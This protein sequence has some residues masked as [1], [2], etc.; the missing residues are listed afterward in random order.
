MATHYMLFKEGRDDV[1]DTQWFVNHFVD[2]VD[3]EKDLKWIE[4]RRIEFQDDRSLGVFSEDGE[5][6]YFISKQRKGDIPN[7]WIEV[8]PNNIIGEL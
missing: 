7:D 4:Q 2:R 5:P 3:R 6:F 1:A 8:R